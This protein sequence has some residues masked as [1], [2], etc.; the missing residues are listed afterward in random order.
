M[1]TN[2]LQMSK[3]AHELAEKIYDI[4]GE[5]YYE[6]VLTNAETLELRGIEADLGTYTLKIE[7]TYKYN[8]LTTKERYIMYVEVLDNENEETVDYSDRGYLNM[9]ECMTDLEEI[10]TLYKGEPE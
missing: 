2:V 8:V 5:K 4:L 3:K 6:L 7:L 10:V 9:K 1:I